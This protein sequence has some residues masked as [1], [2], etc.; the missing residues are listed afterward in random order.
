MRHVR[1]EDSMCKTLSCLVFFCVY[2]VFVF[3]SSSILEVVMWYKNMIDI[4]ELLIRLH[5]LT[6]IGGL[7]Q[8]LMIRVFVYGNGS[9]DIKSNMEK[10]HF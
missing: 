4:W 5:L 7:F 6:E 2:N 1:Q 3:I 8:P 10:F 9:Y